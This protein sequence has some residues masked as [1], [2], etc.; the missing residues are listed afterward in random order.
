MASNRNTKR[1]S[2]N[3]VI[4]EMTL[5]FSEAIAHGM[6]VSELAVLVSR[7]LG[8][9][10]DFC[11]DIAMAGILHDVGKLKLTEQL[12]K[13]RSEAMVV[14]KMK[15]VRMHSAFSREIMKEEGFSESILEMVYHHHENNDGSGY[16]T[17]IAGSD[18]PMG[19]KIIRVC[20]VFSALIS[21]RS[22]RKAFSDKVAV[23][24][25]ID[26]SRHF[27]MKVFLAFLRVINSDDFIK[28]KKL[29]NGSIAGEASNY[30]KENF[31]K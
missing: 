3:E 21:N 25:M 29:I 9:D 26:E 22:Y 2:K 11:N 13:E 31:C 18:I 17:N 7:E 24:L 14:E 10:E 16:P 12:H 1:L 5:D 8:M 20:D 23:E 30:L 4:E 15:Y 19:A 6:I 27:D 28:V